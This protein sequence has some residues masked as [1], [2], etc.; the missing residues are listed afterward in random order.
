VAEI[1]FTRSIRLK[2]GFGIDDLALDE[3]P[4]R[5]HHFFSELVVFAR[6]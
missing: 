6:H 1:A 2:D 4:L 3:V 5:D